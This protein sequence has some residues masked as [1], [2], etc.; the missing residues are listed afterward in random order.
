MDITRSIDDVGRLIE[1]K[2]TEVK[3]EAPGQADL[4]GGE[5]PL[6]KE[7][8]ITFSEASCEPSESNSSKAEE[9]HDD[10]ENVG[11][12]TVSGSEKRDE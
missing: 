9:E 7:V 2:M 10:V 5:E 6:A 4:F 1:Y 8:N 12:W 11:N 3:A